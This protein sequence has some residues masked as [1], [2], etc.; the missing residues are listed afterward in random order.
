MAHFV[1]KPKS[2]QGTGCVLL[3]PLARVRRLLNSVE[4]AAR[5]HNIDQK[6]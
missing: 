6:Y 1:V 2:S 4:S 3:Q 5:G